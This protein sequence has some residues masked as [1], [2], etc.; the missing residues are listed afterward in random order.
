MLIAL[1]IWYIIEIFLFRMLTIKLFK[2]IFLF[3]KIDINE[4]YMHICIYI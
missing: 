4:Y 3:V 2:A 1:K